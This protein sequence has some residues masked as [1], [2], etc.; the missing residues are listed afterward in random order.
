MSDTEG[1]LPTPLKDQVRE[2]WNRRPCG[3]AYGRTEVD[4]GIDLE[5]MAATR[6]ELEPY[7]L[8]LADFESGRGRRVLEIGVG[9]G[10]DFLN[11][12]RHGAEATGVD[13]TPAGVELTRRRLAAAGVP[14]RTYRLVV[15]DAEGL[16][17]EKDSFDI[18]Y[19]YGVLHH[20]PDTERAIHEVYRVLAPGGEFRGMVYHVPSI[21]G[22]MLWTRYCLLRGRFWKSPRQAIYH[23]LESPGTKAY[24][25][26]EMQAMLAR[27][28][29]TE[30]QVRP[31]LSFGDLLQNVR[32]SKYRSP[33]YAIIW[34]LYPR[35]LIRRLGDR[36]G[37][38][39]LMVARKT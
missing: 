19:S 6:Y 23:H 34:K 8:E 31:K 21:V 22:W 10:V 26:Q 4:G 17:F 18:V 28:G 27:A 1:P 37:N 36:Y 12:I 20:T 35:W 2:Y 16:Q 7:I 13:L 11:W 33:V 3:T 14:G 29:F 24:T 9:A 30:I 5:K 32:S 25:V 15:A 39:L 38:A